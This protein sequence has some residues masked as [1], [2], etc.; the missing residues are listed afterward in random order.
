MLKVNFAQAL[1]SGEWNRVR[2]F[3]KNEKWAFIKKLSR[4]LEFSNLGYEL[5]GLSTDPNIRQT[6][7]T[8]FGREEI[9]NRFVVQVENLGAD[10]LIDQI[11]LVGGSASDPEAIY[12]KERFPNSRIT[13]YGIEDSDYY[14]DLNANP[15]NH[16]TLGDIVL[17]SQV[18]EHVWCHEQFFENVVRLAK[19]GGF[20]WI[21]CPASNKVHGSPGYFSAGF[22]STYLRNN[23]HNFHTEIIDA[24]F[25]GTK[26]LYLA[27]H[28]IPGWLSVRA[29]RFPLLFAF[30]NYRFVE[31]I[32][33]ILRYFG[34]LMFL[35]LTNPRLASNERWATEAWILARRL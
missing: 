19:V 1:R 29:H 16:G 17:V 22:T 34:Q 33:L 23:L 13:T 26:R 31:R 27:T 15:S 4:R 28:W 9:L 32:V 12:L 24:G 30:D 6:Y 3:L 21:G 25:F 7:T 11:N 14:L 18:L 10:L 5:S 8:N 2:N 35:T 20:I